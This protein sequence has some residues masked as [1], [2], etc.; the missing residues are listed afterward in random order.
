[1]DAVVL[2]ERPRRR[3]PHTVDAIVIRRPD[4]LAGED[5]PPPPKQ[6]RSAE[7]RARLKA[8]GLALF[9]ER[10]Y[11]GTS[12]E[13]VA[14]R[15]RLAVGGFYQ[16]FRSKR[17][18]LLTL[19]DELLVGMS[20]LDLRL[21]PGI[22]A[23]TGL[24][25]LMSRAF[26]GESPYL[27]AYRAWREAMLSDP[28]LARQEA[29]IRAWTTTRVATVLTHLQQQPGARRGVD[30]RAQ[31][32]LLDSFFWNLLAQASHLPARERRQWV[33]SATHLVYHAMFADPSEHVKGSTR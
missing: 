17:Q 20:Q 19:M 21:E 28:D 3:H 6:K 24:R 16:H 22:D 33:D 2:R 27:G 12:V 7:K 25:A 18:L 29:A 32:R 14:A 13:D 11:E 9:G 4:L 31:S 5:L 26:A 8:A 23:R 1:M 10:G 30:I 15:A